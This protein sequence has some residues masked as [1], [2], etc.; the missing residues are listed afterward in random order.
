MRLLRQSLIVYAYQWFKNGDHPQDQSQIV[1]PKDGSPAHL[2]PG[3]IVRPYP[4]K[5]EQKCRYCQRLLETHGLLDHGDGSGQSVVCPGDWII[6]KG[7]G[8]R[9]IKPAELE[10]I[11]APLD[12]PD[13]P[14][15]DLEELA[16]LDSLDSSEADAFEHSSTVLPSDYQ[17][18][19][20]EIK[21]FEENLDDLLTR[22][23]TAVKDRISKEPFLADALIA[24]IEEFKQ[25]VASFK[26]GL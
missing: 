12:L 19:D 5:S 20:S 10:H 8:F 6:G 17:V 13:T 18:R 23:E 15:N 22:A 4:R 16:S 1:E 14:E 24:R 11:Y 25:R 3:K 21:R 2:S 26:E 7:S 9:A